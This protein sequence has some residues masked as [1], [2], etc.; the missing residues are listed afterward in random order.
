MAALADNSPASTRG[1]VAPVLAQ[2]AQGGFDR[3][4]G[5]SG[6]YAVVLVVNVNVQM[7][8]PLVGAVPLFCGA[9]IQI[10][11]LCRFWQS[12]LRPVPSFRDIHARRGSAPVV[13]DGAAN[14]AFQAIVITVS[15][16]S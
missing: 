13:I 8:R 14:C 6:V 10:G 4:A 2:A 15:S 9:S 1:N 11:K 12:N 5:R 7:R 16:A 3:V